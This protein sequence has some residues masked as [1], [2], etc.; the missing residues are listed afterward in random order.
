MVNS[1]GPKAGL[2]E[3]EA[4]AFLTEQVAYRHS[5]IIEDNLAVTFRGMVIHDPDVAHDV[6]TGCVYWN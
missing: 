3:R 6:H 5:D 4:T 1:T 2:S